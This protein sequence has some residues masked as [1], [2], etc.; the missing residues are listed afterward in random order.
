MAGVAAAARRGQPGD[1]GIDRLVAE[2]E[3]MSDE[4]AERLLAREKEGLGIR[5]QGLGRGFS[6]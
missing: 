1:A 3:A 4:E 6:S 5:D 2:L